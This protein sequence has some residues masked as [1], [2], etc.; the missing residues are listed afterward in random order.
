M[1]SFL[2]SRTCG[3]PLTL[4]PLEIA[5]MQILWD[6]GESNVHQVLEGLDRPLAYTTAMTTVDRLF[7]KGLLDRRKS[8]RA[9]V[10]SPRLSRR[11][12]EHQ[13]LG[14]LMAQL[15]NES[16]VSCLVEG[17]D[18]KNEALLDE[19][20]RKIQIKRRELAERRKA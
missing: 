19:L 16:L 14:H 9:F 2:K 17:V 5:V 12:W 7:K 13:R 10:Y 18:E 11:Q 6:L 3:S 20:E 1:I 8:E 15:S 4:G